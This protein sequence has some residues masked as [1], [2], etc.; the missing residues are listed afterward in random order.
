MLE[1]FS[2]SSDDRLMILTENKSTRAS[3]LQFGT[4]SLNE[5]PRVILTLLIVK[6]LSWVYQ[7]NDL[8]F[9]STLAH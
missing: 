6:K 8:V 2:I 9:F 5:F 1:A 4:I 7:Q 3:A